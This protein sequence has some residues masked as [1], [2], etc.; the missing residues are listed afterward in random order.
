LTLGEL[1]ERTKESIG[2]RQRF[3]ATDP[4]YLTPD[5]AAALLAELARWDLP[6]SQSDNATEPNATIHPVALKEVN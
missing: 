6:L 4:F 1:I 2:R 5:D 3:A